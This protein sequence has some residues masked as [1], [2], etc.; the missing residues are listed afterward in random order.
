MSKSE[1]MTIMVI[2][3]LK[4]HRNLKHFY[5]YYVSKHMSDYFPDLVS[6]NRFVELQ[7]SVIQPLAVG[8]P[9]KFGTIFYA[10]F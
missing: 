10:T 8:L 2:F 7:K 6:Y 4:S 9:T 3:H 1:I 5:L